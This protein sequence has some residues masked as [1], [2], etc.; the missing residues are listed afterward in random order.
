MTGKKIGITVNGIEE[1]CKWDKPSKC[2]RHT[3][4]RDTPIFRTNIHHDDFIEPEYTD[5]MAIFDTEFDENL[6]LTGEGF[7]IDDDTTLNDL[8]LPDAETIEVY[9]AN[10]YAVIKIVQPN[11]RTIINTNFIL[12]DNNYYMSLQ[13]LK[14]ILHKI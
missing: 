7:I 5:P 9:P 3:I 4:H 8:G 6:E 10:G 2:P 12:E 1:E 14:E 13:Q 11:N